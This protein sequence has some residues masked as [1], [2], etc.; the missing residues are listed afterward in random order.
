MRRSRMHTVREHL[1]TV[2]RFTKRGGLQRI[3]GS[4]VIVAAMSACDTWGPHD[5]VTS[6]SADPALTASISVPIISTN[7]ETR[8][9]V[10]F[11]P[12]RCTVGMQFTGPLDIA[13]TAGHNVDL[14]KVTIRLISAPLEGQVSGFVQ[15]SNF[16]DNDDLAEAFGSTQIPGGTIR[17]FRFHTDL[18]CGRTEPDFVAADIQFREV[19]GRKN[20]IMVTLPFGTAIELITQPVSV[21]GQR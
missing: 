19:S 7:G 3:A 11:I 4:L 2:R 14:H 20:S 1:K 12:F 15:A 10:H 21:N 6:P 5:S 8:P 9:A 16:F 17:T 18:L 13:M